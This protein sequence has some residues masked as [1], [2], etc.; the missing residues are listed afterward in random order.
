MSQCACM[1][2]RKKP[3]INE[4]EELSDSSKSDIAIASTPCLKPKPKRRLGFKMGDFRR[5][6]PDRILQCFGQ[7]EI[8]MTKLEKTIKASLLIQKWY[9]SYMARLE[10]RRRYTWTIFQTLEYAG[11]QDQVKLYNFFNAL[12]THIPQTVNRDGYNSKGPSRCSSFDNLDLE[13]EDESPEEDFTYDQEDK[14]ALRHFG[15]EFPYTEEKITQLIEIFRKHRHYRLPPKVLAD[16]LRRAI[17]T[18]RKLPN[19]NVVSTALSKQITVCGDLHGKFDDLLVIL[20]KN[21]LPSAENPYIFNGDFVD[22]GKRGLEVILVLLLCLIAFP[23]GVYLNRGNHEDHIMNQRYG[24]IRE[25]QLK[26]RKNHERI[27]KLFES[28]YRWLPLGT[29]VNNRVLIVHG[30]ISDTT[31]LEMIRSLEREKYISLLRPPLCD[32]SAPGADAINKVEWKQVFDILWSDPQETKGCIPNSLRG[33]GTYFGPDVTKKFLEDN[34]LSYIVRSHECKPDGYEMCH[35]NLIITIFSASNY[36]E[37]GSNNGAYVK[38][39]GSNLEP[40]FVQYMANAGRRKLNFYQRM[41][42]VE[43]GATKELQA[44]ILNNRAIIEEEFAKSDP[45]NIGSIS[46]TQ[47]CITLEKCTGLQIPWRLLKEKLVTID[48]ESKMVQYQ[49][50]FDIKGTRLN[51]VQGAS[52]VVETLYRNKSSLEAIFRIIDKDNSGYISLDELAD[53]CN[54]IKEHMPCNMTEEQL[55][56]I[57]RMM[58][59]NKDGLVDLNEFLETFRMVD[60]ES[61]QKNMPMSPE[62]SILAGNTRS[63]KPSSKGLNSPPK[64]LKQPQSQENNIFVEAANAL[65][66]PQENTNETDN[67]GLNQGEKVSLKV[68]IHNCNSNPEGSELENTLLP[69][70]R[71]GLKTSPVLSS[72]RGS[73]I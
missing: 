19:I 36:Y 3:V 44:Q 46:L 60:P 14:K 59:I 15:L 30:G 8:E 18:L 33:A 5:I 27:L 50:T 23:G 58:D 67:P 70:H 32:S 26:Y 66:A 55:S 31:D 20:H 24:F 16:V 21:G 29:I 22:R 35:N 63:P 72:R 34:R 13:F 42:L 28:V 47:W 11:E 48:P 45:E 7:D 62:N 56:E 57:C 12:L 2:L 65:E 68:Q 10:V 6:I 53:A 61:K 73:Q 49:T 69:V 39:M 17:T 9:R 52:T 54:L 4:D 71:N 43:S 40:H 38:L 37:I 41:G 51:S 64:I 1:K 25:I